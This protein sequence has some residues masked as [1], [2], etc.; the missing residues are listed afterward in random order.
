M[1]NVRPKQDRISVWTKTAAHESLQARA[2]LAAAA[3]RAARAE[4]SV[5]GRRR[6]ERLAPAAAAAP[7]AGR[8]PAACCSTAWR[9]ASQ[10]PRAR[11]AHPCIPRNTPAHAPPQTNVGRQLK[12]MLQIP[13]QAR[14]GFMAHNDAKRDDRRAKERYT[15]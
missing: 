10:C 1:V 12:E 2:W 13:D 9:R 3:E 6:R 14:I 4:Q 8:L 5:A 11:P 15:V 7:G